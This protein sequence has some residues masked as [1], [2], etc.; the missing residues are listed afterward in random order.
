MTDYRQVLGLLTEHGV[1]FIVIGGAAAVL[2]GSSRLTQDL[3]VVYPRFLHP[4]PDP[5][6]DA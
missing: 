2:P 3:D 1:E 6:L 5:T 4:S